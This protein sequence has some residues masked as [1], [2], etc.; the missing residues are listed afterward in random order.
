MQLQ[1]VRQR[2][3]KSGHSLIVLRVRGVSQKRKWESLYIFCQR[4]KQSNHLHSRYRN[5][6]YFKLYLVT[7]DT[8]EA[9][10]GLRISDFERIDVILHELLVVLVVLLVTIATSSCDKC[11]RPKCY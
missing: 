1:S 3:S 4:K 2:C 11:R 8:S 10:Q 9:E 6:F 7:I 5:S